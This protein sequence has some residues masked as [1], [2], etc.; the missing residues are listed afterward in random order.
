MTAA[1]TLN[2]APGTW[3]LDTAHTVIEFSVR[4]MMVSKVKG[5]FLTFEGAITVAD[6]VE[7]SK[8]AVSID[9]SS[10]DTGN[11][12][13]DGHLRTTDFFDIEKHNT[14]AFASTGIKSDGGD[15]AI[16]GD[17]TING[18]TKPVELAVEFGGVAG[19]VAGFEAKATVNRSDFGVN[20]QIPME[21]GGVVIGDKVT[22]NLDVEAKLEKVS[23]DA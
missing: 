7:D 2:L 18:I 5:K 9:V 8:V 17:L 21:N 12:Q 1:S 22:I 23:A 14:I 6:E 13:R 3:N 11:A 16:T 10:V 15:W 19:E 4:H 20:F